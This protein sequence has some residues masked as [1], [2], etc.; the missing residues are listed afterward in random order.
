MLAVILVSDFLQDLLFVDAN[1][2][3]DD[4]VQHGKLAWGGGQ[5]FLGH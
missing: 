2:P 1:K 3:T 4:L 5:A